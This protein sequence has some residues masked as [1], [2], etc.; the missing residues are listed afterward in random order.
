VN[1]SGGVFTWGDTLYGGNVTYFAYD[2]NG[3]LIDVS[4]Q[5]TSGVQYIFASEGTFA[6]LKSDGTVV[7]WAESSSTGVQKYKPDNLTNVQTI[8][9]TGFFSVA[10][11]FAFAALVSNTP[12]GNIPGPVQSLTAS[13]T[14]TTFILNWLAPLV[15]PESVSSYKIYNVSN[16]EIAS[17][18][19]SLL[20]YTVTGLSPDTSYTYRV[21]AAS[22]SGTSSL[23]SV[24]AS[25]S[26]PTPGVP[27]SL[28]ATPTT[29]TMVL[30]WGVPATNAA[31]VSTYK[32]YDASDTLIAS[33]ASLTY[34]VTGLTPSTSYTFKVSA[35]NANGDESAKASVTQSTNA[36]VE[37]GTNSIVISDI[38]GSGIME[39]TPS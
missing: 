10:P 18:S 31:Y 7:S 29:T 34:T 11:N 9:S 3:T 2:E 22:S 25:T 27:T 20:T 6:A 26:I 35:A 16:V 23:E 4:S 17:I 36:N 15:H 13:T 33:T 1:S 12:I 14:T 39:C 19:S 8:Y 32:V 37:P 28:T 21:A 38:L 30:N 24:T 5:L